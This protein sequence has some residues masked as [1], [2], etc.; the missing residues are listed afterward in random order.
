MAVRPDNGKVYVSNLE[1]RNHVRFEPLAASGM[2]GHI[3]EYISVITGTTPSPHHLNPH[4][5][6]GV[7][8]GSQSERD[9]SLAFPTDMVFAPNGLTLFVA[10]FRLGQDR[11]ARRNALEGGTISA[12]RSRWGQGPSGL[13]LDTAH[14]RLYVMNRIDHTVSV[15]SNASS[16]ARAQTAVV[17]LRYDP[18]PAAAK[19][20][21]RF[22]Y[23][24]HGTSGHGDNACASCHIF[25]D[26]DSLAWD[27]GDP[28]GSVVANP[29]PFRLGTGGPFHPMKGPMTT[30]SLRGMADAGPMHWRGDRTGGTTGGDPLD[31][32]LA[33][34]AFNP[35]FV[36]LL[37]RSA[38]LTATEMQQF[39]DFILSVRYPPNPIRALSNVPTAAESAGETFYTT[40]IVDT[41]TCNGCHALPL[42]TDGFSS[43]EGETQEFK[44]AHLRNLY[45]KV[46][47][48]GLPTGVLGG[49]GSTGD[50]VRGF[51]FLHD[52]S[53]PT[54]FNFLR[55]SVFNF[56]TG[57]TANTRRRNVEAFVLA[58]DTGLRPAVG[59]Q[60]SVN[61][62]S[63]AD[64]NVISRIDLLVGRDD[65]GDCELVV[66]GVVSGEA[67][68]W[69]YAGGN[70]FRSDRVLEPLIGKTSL[71]A[72]A[73]TA[74]QEQ[75]YTCVPPG[76]GTRIGVD[77]DGDGQFRPRR[78]RR[79][80]RSGRPPQPDPG[81]GDAGH[82]RHRHH[83]AGTPTG[84]V[85]AT[86]HLDADRRAHGYGHGDAH[87]DQRHSRH[88]HADR[89]A[90]RHGDRDAHADQRRARDQYAD[91]HPDR[92]QHA[93]RA[94]HAGGALQRQWVGPE[95]QG[96]G[97]PQ[98]RAGRRREAHGQGRGPARDHHPTGHRSGGE[99]RHRRPDRPRHQSGGA[100][101]HGAA[102]RGFAGLV[103][104]I[105]QVEV[106]R[107]HR[108]ARRRHLEGAGQGPQ[109]PVAG[110]VQ[111]QGAREERQFPGRHRQPGAGRHPRGTG[112]GRRRSLR[113]RALQSRLAR[114]GVP[115]GE[116]VAEVR[117]RQVVAG[118]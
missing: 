57:G 12:S 24:A 44:I 62:G 88:Q 86:T 40:N 67:R 8:T 30:Q 103:G 66:K 49:T 83:R 117:L 76:S 90:H 63:V 95:G 60:V 16:N 28:F 39:T 11:R 107:P 72:L 25:G 51:G 52:G 50:Q 89:R 14:D 68:G 47:M 32:D 100:Q 2:Q 114:P 17:P 80:L 22:L 92:E 27:L 43:F 70:N 46:G 41:R 4:V 79:G 5:S 81:Y 56:G 101:P 78:A 54:V 31:E 38:E 116:H 98:R 35:A 113:P 23:D 73:G 18:S 118:C 74:G 84:T 96:E 85:A 34:K 105:R 53:I 94:R 58:L 48:F 9:Q 1:S 65:A 15:V 59:Q 20:G 111:G 19:V 77:R 37:G 109:Q 55:A 6:Y 110:A 3:T 87:A 75:I 99:R 104:R 61:P 71:R 45:Q 10:A 106:P 91:R 97:D 7:A 21:R 13:A 36:G 33:F 115:A 29:N 64:A 112:A 108:G 42:G 102:G 69:V 93:D 82:D 26:F